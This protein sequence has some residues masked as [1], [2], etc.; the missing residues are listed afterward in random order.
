MKPPDPV[1]AP[2]IPSVRLGE[3]KD[4]A[5]GVVT[6][7][8]TLDGRIAGETARALGDRLRFLNSYQYQNQ[9]R[10]PLVAI[11]R[12]FPKQALVHDKPAVSRFPD[13]RWEAFRPG[14][15][16]GLLPLFS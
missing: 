13:R 4:M 6:A 14:I 7:S 8:A 9:S 1:F 11:E 16:C 12:I 15:L 10:Q 3:L 5:Q 2:P